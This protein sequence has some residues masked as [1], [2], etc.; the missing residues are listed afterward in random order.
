MYCAEIDNKETLENMKRKTGLISTIAL[1]IGIFMASSLPVNAGAK[2]IQID[3]D[4]L[5]VIVMQ[6]KP[7][8]KRFVVKKS[9]DPSLYHRYCQQLDEC[10]STKVKMSPG[11]K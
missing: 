4:T 8:H 1:V 10:L 11:H 3:G 5:K 6:G 7:P 2:V 9:V